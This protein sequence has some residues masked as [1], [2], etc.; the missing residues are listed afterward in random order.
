[1]VGAQDVPQSQHINDL[2]KGAGEKGPL[3][4]KGYFQLRSHPC[5]ASAMQP[6]ARTRLIMV[7]FDARES[8]SLAVAAR[9]SGKVPNTIRLWAER[10]RRLSA[11]KAA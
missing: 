9:L 6:R 5:E 3:K 8:I 1:V 10:Y 11:N 2:R 4:P 7:P